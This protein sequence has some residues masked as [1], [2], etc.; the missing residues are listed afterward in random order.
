MVLLGLKGLEV[1]FA[2]ILLHFAG[3]VTFKGQRCID[4]V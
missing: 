1:S 3:Y 2:L 4:G